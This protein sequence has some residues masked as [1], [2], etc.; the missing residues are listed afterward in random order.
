MLTNMGDSGSPEERFE[1]EYFS[2]LDGP[3]SDDVFFE[4]MK[5][6]K[7]RFFQYLL[8]EKEI[9]LITLGLLVE[10]KYISRP[11]IWANVAAIKVHLFEYPVVDWLLVWY[12]NIGILVALL[13]FFT[14]TT[15]EPLPSWYYTLG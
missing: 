1:H 2:I 11:A 15:E 12:A 14:Y 6:R 4:L 3:I 5:N 9:T 10:K 8:A 7:Y 13:A